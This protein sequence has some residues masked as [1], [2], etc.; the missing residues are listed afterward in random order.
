MLSLMI[1]GNGKALIPANNCNISIC[2]WFSD[3]VLR[4][5]NVYGVPVA[6]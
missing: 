4:Y 2:M 1:D 3:G 5:G 6:K